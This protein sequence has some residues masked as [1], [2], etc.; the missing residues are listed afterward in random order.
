MDRRTVPV[1]VAIGV[2]GVI[3]GFSTA[4][5]DADPT[6]VQ[7]SSS[8]VLMIFGSGFIPEIYE[9]VRP[10]LEEAGYLVNVASRTKSIL[11]AKNSSLE[12]LP[13][14]LL[15][16]VQVTD[17]AAIIFACDN[18]LSD[19][20]AYPDTDRIAQEAAAAQI[21]LGGI[22]TGPNLLGHAGVLE[23]RTVTAVVH[24]CARLNNY[25]GATCTG[26][27]VEQDGLFVTA[28]DRWDSTLFL[29]AILATL[30]PEPEA[31]SSSEPRPRLCGREARKPPRRYCVPGVSQETPSDL[32]PDCR[33]RSRP[34]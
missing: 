20:T 24:I 6:G 22:C 34:R 29:K 33:S 15:K 27:R 13:D 21:L 32:V 4:W 23:G 9:V 12:V 14:L 7:T 17:Y 25:Y 5:A 11:R 18:D 1:I 8:T 3:L 10:G 26:S 30:Q 2:V 19:G 31:E 28:E 16:D